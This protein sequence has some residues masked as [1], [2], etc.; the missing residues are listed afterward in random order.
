MTAVGFGRRSQSVDWLSIFAIGEMD[1]RV[2]YEAID[3]E[4]DGVSESDLNM[5]SVG[6]TWTF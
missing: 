4:A 1:I 6:L 5:I 2:E 3:L